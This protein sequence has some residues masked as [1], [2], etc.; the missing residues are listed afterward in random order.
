[1]S[2]EK[3]LVNHVAYVLDMSGS[4]SSYEGKMRSLIEGSLKAM[5]NSARTMNQE[6]YFSL[7]MFADTVQAVCVDV[8]I[9]DADLSRV[10]FK[11]GGLTALIDGILKAVRDGLNLQVK[12]KETEDHAYLLNV[13]T[14][15]EENRSKTSVADLKTILKRLNDRWTIAVQVPDA[16][17]VF[18]AKNLGFDADNIEIW[19]AGSSR[20]LEESLDSFT[21]GYD[22]YVSSRSTGATRSVNFYAKTDLST[23]SKSTVKGT[24]MEVSGKLYPCQS[25]PIQIRDF[26]ENVTNRPYVKGNAYY[27]LV[28]P[29]LIQEGKDIVIVNTVAKDGKKYGGAEARH[30]LGL[31]DGR[32]K[33]TPGDHGDWRVFVQSTSVNRK[34]EK[35]TSVFV[36]D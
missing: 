34:I 26:V 22:S 31:P 33:L 8:P 10:S 6:T 3:K 21:R 19:K 23:L 7:Y 17:G 27:E 24:L 32:F 5:Q 13:I 9:E 28:K 15:G 18:F 1:M 12:H 35:G 2:K 36:K 29:E 4:M 25:G 11:T 30:I 14:D 20:G 16:N